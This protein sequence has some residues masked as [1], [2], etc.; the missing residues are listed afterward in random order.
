MSRDE[1]IPVHTIGELLEEYPYRTLATDLGI[2]RVQ[3]ETVSVALVVHALEPTDPMAVFR[4]DLLNGPHLQGDLLILSTP[5]ALRLLS[6]QLI[7]HLDPTAIEDLFG[8][9]QLRLESFSDKT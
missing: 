9:L 4:H 1:E 5:R 8:E 7:Q 2:V 6:K 3:E